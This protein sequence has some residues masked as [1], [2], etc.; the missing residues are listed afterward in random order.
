MRSR[1]DLRAFIELPYRLHANGT[2]WIPQLRL[3]RRLFLSPRFNAF[4]KHG[5][6]RAVP[7]AGADDRVVGRISAQV[8]RAF[9]DYQQNDWGMFGFLELEDDP[10][11]DGRAA[12]GGLRLAARAGP[13]PRR[14]PDGLH[15]ARRVRR[16]RGR[17]RASADG[18]P[19]LAPALLPRALRAGRAREGGR[20]LHVG[21][22]HL[23]QGER[24]ARDLGARRE[25][26]VR[27]RDPPAPDEPA[28]ACGRTSTCSARSTTR[29]GRGTGAS[30]RSR[31]RTSTPTPRSCTSSSTPTGSWSPRPPT[32]RRVGAAITIPDI[33]QVQKL[34]NGRLLPLGWLALPAAQAHH[35]PLPRRL[36]RREAGLPAHRRRRGA[37]R[38]ALQHLGAHARQVGRDGLDPR[39][40]TPR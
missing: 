2:P 25:A 36:P 5:E 4:F 18:A 19:A 13:R 30:C 24:A 38:R 21:A 22:A 20:P 10:G 32:A 7:G 9:N 34:M 29:P 1:A 17:L 37:L 12:R 40:A 31:R 16:P 23:R 8:D 3:E 6:A 11:G 35:R 33:N 39:D 28:L 27:A 14:R 26:R 15:D